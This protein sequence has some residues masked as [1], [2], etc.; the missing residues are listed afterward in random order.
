M[1]ALR[2]AG[3][4]AAGAAGVAGVTNPSMGQEQRRQG[5]HG[6]NGSELLVAVAVAVA[7]IVT[8][9]RCVQC[10]LHEKSLSIVCTQYCTGCTHY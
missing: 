10:T 4:Q 7:V 1:S 3:T 9:T 2:C 5:K 6:K 8:V